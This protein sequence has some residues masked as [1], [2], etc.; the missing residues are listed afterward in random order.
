MLLQSHAG[1]IEPLPALPDAWS[2]G[3]VVGLTARNGFIVDLTWSNKK[4]NSFTIRSSAGKK[5]TLRYG[6][7]PS[8]IIINGS[9]DGLVVDMTN[10]TVSFQSTKGASYNV[11][12][13]DASDVKN[14]EE[15]DKVINYQYFDLMGRE[16]AQPTQGIYIVKETYASKKVVATKKFV[17]ID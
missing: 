8:K 10:K 5:C 13:G 6:N 3:S 9:K 12:L 14:V 16:I 11:T 17:T 7:D 2:N 1:Y 15:S 4:L